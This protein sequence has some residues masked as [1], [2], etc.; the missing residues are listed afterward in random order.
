M[1]ETF[2]MQLYEHIVGD[3]DCDGC[4]YSPQ[5]KCDCGGLVHNEYDDE[6]Y[7]NIYLTYRCDKCESTDKPVL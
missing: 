1:S 4:Y 5:S 2:K 6:D 3:E 7:D